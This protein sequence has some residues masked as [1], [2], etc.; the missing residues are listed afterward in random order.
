MLLG[1][2]ECCW[3]LSDAVGC[4]LASLCSWAAATIS[5]CWMLL[6]A[7]GCCQGATPSPLLPFLLSGCPFPFQ[8]LAA[9][10]SGLSA[11]CLQPWL[12]I[13]NVG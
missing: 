7:V 3:M 6:D 4:V 11:C 10:P 13:E 12:P 5:C 9:V 1:V 2:V 8:L